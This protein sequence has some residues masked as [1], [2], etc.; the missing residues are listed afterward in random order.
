MWV[1]PL[2]S[3]SSWMNWNPGRPTLSNDWWSV[4][5]V[6]LAVIVVMPSA[7]NGSIHSR[8]IGATASFP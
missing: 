5:P 2:Y 1:T 3:I 7:R 4:P 6:F 8:K